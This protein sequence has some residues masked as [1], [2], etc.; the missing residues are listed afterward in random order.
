MYYPAQIPN[1]SQSAFGQVHPAAPCR[2]SQRPGPVGRWIKKP[3]IA[4]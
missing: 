2:T 1:L 3:G 4:T